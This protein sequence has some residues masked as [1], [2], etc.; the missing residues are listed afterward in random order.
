MIRREVIV[1]ARR[2]DILDIPIESLAEKMGGGLATPF[3]SQGSSGV[4]SLAAFILL[5]ATFLSLLP[6]SGRA[7]EQSCCKSHGDTLQPLYLQEIYQE[8]RRVRSSAAA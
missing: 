2:V 6:Q 1:L 7:F 4:P 5:F 8:S 3:L